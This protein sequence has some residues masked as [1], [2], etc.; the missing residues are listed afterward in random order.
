M[1]PTKI[2]STP[3]DPKLDNNKSEA[4]PGHSC[5]F[6]FSSEYT[7]EINANAEVVRYRTASFLLEYL[8]DTVKQLVQY[9]HYEQWNLVDSTSRLSSIAVARSTFI[10]TVPSLMPME[11]Y[12]RKMMEPTKNCC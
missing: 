8:Y 9:K 12:W 4:R 5:L 3:P 11:L 7:N 2:F 10:S 6:D 1:N